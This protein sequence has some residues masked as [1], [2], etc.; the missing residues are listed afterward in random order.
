MSISFIIIHDHLT[1]LI[2]LLMKRT[3][4]AIPRR[5]EEGDEDDGDDYSMYWEKDEAS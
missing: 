4:L 5:Q 2:G 3:E 1:Q